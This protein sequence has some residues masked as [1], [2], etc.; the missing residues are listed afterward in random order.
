VAL[1]QIAYEASQNQLTSFKEIESMMEAAYA[2]YLKA[3]KI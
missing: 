2:M 3:G 1:S